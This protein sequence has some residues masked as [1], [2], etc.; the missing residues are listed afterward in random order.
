MGT[1]AVILWALLL[2]F[3]LRVTGQLLVVA[4][5]GGPLPP[6]EQWSSG[7]LPYP[8]L[9]VA[10]VLIVAAYGK[11]CLDFTRGQGFFVRRR[12]GLGRGLLVFAA[13][14]W[15]AMIARYVVR[16]TRMP[17][18]RWLGGTIPIFFHFVLATF[19]LVVGLYHFPR[20]G[21]AATSR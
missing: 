8:V 9:V 3:V 14:Y 17:D 15:A 7:I 11:V 20:P 18:Q 1:T 16:M 12:R 4:G 13:L 2:L 5:W 6:F 19:I 21:R 10:Q